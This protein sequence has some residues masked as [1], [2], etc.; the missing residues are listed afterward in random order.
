MTGRICRR[1]RSGVVWSEASGFVINIY[2]L[3]ECVFLENADFSINKR[4]K[5]QDL[6]KDQNW[7]CEFLVLI[8]CKRQRVYYILS[9][10][11]GSPTY[12]VS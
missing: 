8:K 3:F 4:I 10:N 9:L 12:I 2:L 6:E 1:R 5:R 11:L 7:V